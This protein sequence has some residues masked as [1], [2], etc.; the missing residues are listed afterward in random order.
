VTTDQHPLFGE[1]ED[2][3]RLGRAQEAVLGALNAHQSL[4]ADEAGAIIHEQRGRHDRDE[5]CEWCGG[6][7]RRVLDSLEA[8][9][10]ARHLLSTGEWKRRATA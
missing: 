7:G 4:Y 2:V 6:D 1:R 8:R 10:L 3:A 9:G 5:R